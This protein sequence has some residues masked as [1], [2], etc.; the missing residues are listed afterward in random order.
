MVSVMFG[1]E[2]VRKGEGGSRGKGGG[3]EGGEEGE[4]GGRGGRRGGRRGGKGE[5]PFAHKSS[6]QTLCLAR[7][8][9]KICN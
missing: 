6:L 2:G 4:K 7:I 1:G 9:L 3:E 8:Y 5:V